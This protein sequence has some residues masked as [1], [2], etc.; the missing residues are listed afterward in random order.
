MSDD[1]YVRSEY[2]DGE[3]RVLSKQDGYLYLFRAPTCERENY[4]VE[5]DVRWRKTPGSSYGILFGI[6]DDFG[7]YY[8]FDVNTDY[9]Q[10]RLYR[11]SPSGFTRIAAPTYSSAIH[12]GTASNHLEITRDYNRIALYINGTKLGTWWDKEILG[13]SGVGIISSPYTGSPTSDARFDNF[14]VVNLITD[15]VWTQ[16][17]DRTNV[18]ICNS[19]TS[20]NYAEPAS[21]ELEW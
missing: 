2:R 21:I 4:T 10:F 18:T 13:P 16:G 12:G 11:R 20:E 7:S 9:Q 6:T 17:V 5:V 8:L 14:S 15:N 1:D 19:P 3:Y